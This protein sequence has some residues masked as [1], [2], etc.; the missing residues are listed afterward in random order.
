MAARLDRKISFVRREEVARDAL[1]APVMQELPI[2]AA[3]GAIEPLEV[4]RLSEFGIEGASSGLL[5]VVRLTAAVR[6][7]SVHDFAAFDGNQYA[8]KS[9]KE[10][11]GSRGGWVELVLV[12]EV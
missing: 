9:I 7:V 12:R 2:A 4:A 3:W 11:A 5:V 10:R 6:S 1:N 8:I